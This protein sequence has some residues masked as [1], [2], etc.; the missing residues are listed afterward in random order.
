MSDKNP[1][2][3]ATAARI[4]REHLHG[5]WK[6]VTP[7]NIVV[8]RIR[9]V[10]ISLKKNIF[11]FNSWTVTNLKFFAP[12]ILILKKNF[13]TSVFFSKEKYFPCMKNIVKM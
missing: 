11:K 1:E 4:C 6:H 12:R 3:R 13:L 5:V 8:K 10:N 9:Y 7:D 2:M